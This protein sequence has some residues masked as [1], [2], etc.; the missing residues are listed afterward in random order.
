MPKHFFFKILLVLLLLVGKYVSA[1]H[2]K[3]ISQDDEK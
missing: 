2:T 3:S 1:L